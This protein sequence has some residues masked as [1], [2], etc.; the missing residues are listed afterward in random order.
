MT[1][2]TASSAVSST[3]QRSIFSPPTHPQVTHLT[4]AASAFSRTTSVSTLRSTS[5]ARTSSTPATARPCGRELLGEALEQLPLDLREV[6][7][8]HAA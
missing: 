2:S 1:L 5:A 6:L 7:V 4:P 8:H 3:G